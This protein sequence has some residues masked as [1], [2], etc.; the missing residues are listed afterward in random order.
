M[1]ANGVSAAISGL[2]ASPRF[3]HRRNH[4]Q[5]GGAKKRTCPSMRTPHGSSYDPVTAAL[6]PFP[7]RLRGYSIDVQL[8][9]GSTKLRVHRSDR[10]R[11]ESTHDFTDGRVRRHAGC[12]FAK[13]E[14]LSAGSFRCDWVTQRQQTGQCDQAPPD[15]RRRFR[16]EL[17][18]AHSVPRDEIPR[19]MHRRKGVRRQDHSLAL[20][21]RTYIHRSPVILA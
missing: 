2:P 12:P 9:P 16:L 4:E 15:R 18:A 8:W 20:G 10:C 11:D 13:A 5:R 17:F 3:T 19:L 7:L 1:A 21:P 6:T 14:G